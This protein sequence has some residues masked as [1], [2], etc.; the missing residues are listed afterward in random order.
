[1]DNNLIKADIVFN[2]KPD[3][4]PYNCRISYKVPQVCLIL[5]FC[6]WGSKCSLLKIQIIDYFLKSNNMDYL[7]SFI[8]GNKKIPVVKIDPLVNKALQISI[9]YNLVVPE[10][11]GKYKLSQSGKCYVEQIM[12]EEKLLDNEIA[13]LKQLSKKLSEEKIKQLF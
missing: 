6:G 2:K 1:M 5:F 4:V 11:T 7:I 10:K 8:D 13:S 3:A 12:Q 9:A